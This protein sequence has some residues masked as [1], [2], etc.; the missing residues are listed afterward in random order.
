M[1]GTLEKEVAS[2]PL[3]KDSSYSNSRKNGLLN[4]MTPAATVPLLFGCFHT[5]VLGGRLECFQDGNACLFF[6]KGMIND[7][8]QR[9]RRCKVNV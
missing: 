9:A 5:L 8:R 4:F 6:P 2:Y 1:P 7:V 3:S